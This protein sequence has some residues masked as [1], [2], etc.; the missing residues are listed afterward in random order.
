MQQFALSR[1]SIEH[2]LSNATGLRQIFEV[3]EEAVATHLCGDP[4]YEAI[5]NSDAFQ[6]LKD[7]RFLGAIDYLLRPNGQPANKRHTRYQHSLCVALL[8]L[9]H[10]QLAGLSKRE[11]RSL[12]VAALLHDIGHAPLSHSVE[13]AF[14]SIF[15]I[16]HHIAGNLIISGSAPV[17]KSLPAT[18]RRYGVD[19]GELLSLIS[20]NSKL[21]FA[22]LFGAPVNIDTIEAISRSY[23]Y[24]SKEYVE[25]LPLHV[26]FAVSGVLLN[27]IQVGHEAILDKF[28]DL[29]NLVYAKLIQSPLA[30]GADFLARDYINRFKHAMRWQTY[31]ASESTLLR[32]HKELKI[33]LLSLPA[34]LRKV[35]LDTPNAVHI[36]YKKREFK[37][38]KEISVRKPE[39]LERRYYQTKTIERIALQM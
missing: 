35:D 8:G 17:G 36:E 12:V 9:A 14:A 27:D 24:I 39:D 21:E 15:K 37:I 25:T 4:L 1:T 23:T 16:N 30:I 31:F 34:R 20:G 7:I 10:A 11:E 28:W 29:K 19:P 18:L 33:A 2:Y 32:D 3:S 38:N 6:R 13:P 26:L 22:P 5:I